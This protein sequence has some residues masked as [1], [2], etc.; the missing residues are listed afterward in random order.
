MVATKPISLAVFPKRSPF[1]FQ[2]L[3]L[4]PALWP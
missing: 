1:P 4:E 2:G 3:Q